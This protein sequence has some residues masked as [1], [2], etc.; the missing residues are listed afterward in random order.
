MVTAVSVKIFSFFQNTCSYMIFA[1]YCFFS[2]LTSFF[3]QSFHP[4]HFFCVLIF[5]KSTIKNNRRSNVVS[6]AAILNEFLSNFY[7][8]KTKRGVFYHG[9]LLIF[10]TQQ[11][12]PHFVPFLDCFI[13]VFTVCFALSPFY[14]LWLFYVL[15]IS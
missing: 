5:I 12:L 1:K 8:Q 13:Y 7:C 4:H 14:F 6:S 3:G 10:S 9:F 11:I 15:I 2:S